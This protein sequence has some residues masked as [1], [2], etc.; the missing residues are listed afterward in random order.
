M[1]EPHQLRRELGVLP[2]T[3]LG[4]GSI[5]GT[6]IFVSIGLGAAAA[7][8]AVLPAVVVA[9]LVATCNGL[10]S[11]QLAARHPVSG[12]TYEYGH[13]ELTPL[14]GF[15]A[16]WMFLSAKSA[17]AAAAA[18]GFAGYTLAVIEHDG[19]AG[20]L[21]PLALGAVVILTVLTAGGIRRSSQV[22][23]LIVTLTIGALTTFVLSGWETAWRHAAD[24]L[25]FST[26]TPKDFLEA[27]ALMFVAFT[28]YGRVAT[29]GEEVRAPRRTIPIAIITT[30]ATSMAIYVVVT[31]VAVASSGAPAL[32]DAT[33]G[34]VAPLAVL[35]RGFAA[36]WVAWVVAAGAVTAMLGVL[37]NLLLGLSR[38]LLAMARRGDAPKPLAT[39]IDGVTPRAAVIT[40]GVVIACLVLIGDIGITWSFSA[41]TVLI[42]YAITNLAALALPADARFVPRWVAMIGLLGCLGLAFWVE[43]RAWIAGLVVLA[44]GHGLRLLFRRG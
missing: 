40:I 15:T 17:S 8:A 28:G 1:S 13:R 18:L 7:G 39:V 14:L 43:P 9:A 22:N 34:A 21:V 29:L 11:A 4:L 38:V 25:S 3:L 27:A 20:I 30:L 37:L 6:G 35:A 33:G 24:N 26:A 23:T 10:S 16:G 19:G 44:I 32:A 41:F 36:P 12:G 5:L 2:A 42:Y 31:L